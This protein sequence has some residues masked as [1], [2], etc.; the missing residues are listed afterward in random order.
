MTV[1]AGD[2][3]LVGNQLANVLE[4]GAGNDTIQA[5]AGDDTLIGGEG[6][7]LLQGGTGNNLYLFNLGD[8]QDIVDTTDAS[9]QDNHRILLGQGIDTNDVQLV[10]FSNTTPNLHLDFSNTNDSLTVID[11]F[12][13]ST[14]IEFADGTIWTY[15][16]LM[17]QITQPPLLTGT[18]SQFVNGTENQPYILSIADLLQGYTD[19]EQQPLTVVNLQA[20]H[21]SIVDNQ[22][23]TY[24]FTPDVNYYGTVNLSYLVMDSSGGFIEAENSF[25]LDWVNLAAPTLTGVL[26]ELNSQEDSSYQISVAELLQ[27]YT[28]ADGDPLTIINLQA[29]TGKLTDNQNGIYS[30]IPNPDF[31]GIVNLTYQISDGQD[32]IIEVAQTINVAPIPSRNYHQTKPSTRRYSWLPPWPTSPPKS[33]AS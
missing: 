24:T 12:N 15:D 5:G 6:N 7:D 1:G 22:N 32:G 29:D 16:S 9:Q 8:G 2:N 33:S 20:S 21:G 4:A 26:A 19:A 10:V 30:F 14:T 27:G 17:E 31:N 18:A 25:T 28:D 3:T 11:F 23:G 13:A